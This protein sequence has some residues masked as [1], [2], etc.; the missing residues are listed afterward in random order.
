MTAELLIQMLELEP[1]PEGGFYKRTF[2][3]EQQRFSSILFLLIE[4]NFSAFH[5][6][7]SNEQWNWY[8]GDAIHI[9]EIDNNGKYHET[10]LSE[11]HFQ[12]QH[13]VKGNTW[14]ASECVGNLGYALC[15]CTVIPAFHFKDFELSNATKLIHQF[16]EQT[17]II[18]RLTR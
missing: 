13:I 16:P 4:N 15:G 11:T 9:H 17:E 7:K 5:K 8:L 10:K 2:I 14:F 1:H 3:D 6:I 12:F 18:K